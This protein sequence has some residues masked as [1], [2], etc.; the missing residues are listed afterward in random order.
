MLDEVFDRG[1]GLLILR[2]CLINFSKGMIHKCSSGMLDCM[3]DRDASL[4]V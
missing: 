2:G 4:S 1:A 3:F